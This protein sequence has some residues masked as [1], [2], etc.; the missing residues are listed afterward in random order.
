MALPMIYILLPSIATSWPALAPVFSAVAGTLGYGALREEDFT[1]VELRNRMN[2]IELVI[3]NTE[4]ISQTL[5]SETDV[6]FTKD[7]ITL[8]IQVDV[9]GK[10]KIK[11]WGPR[12]QNQLHEI[13]TQFAQQ[14]IQQY[15]YNKISQE[16]PQ[17]GFSVVNENTDEK[18]SI[19]LQIRRWR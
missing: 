18:D 6:L 2:S 5:N 12:T 1:R 8:G 13:G 3:P 14:I 10:C 9:R 4:V 7:D 16:L 17:K 19:H 11:V 15:V